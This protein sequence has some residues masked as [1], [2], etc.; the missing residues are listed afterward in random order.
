[1]NPKMHID[2][3]QGHKSRAHT[4]KK[5]TFSGKTEINRM[6]IKI[7]NNQVYHFVAVQKHFLKKRE[8]LIK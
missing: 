2:C 1:M 3:F 7:G 5:P 4:L 8:I 6:K